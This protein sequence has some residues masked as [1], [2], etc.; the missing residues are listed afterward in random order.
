M[1]VALL[2]VLMI[3]TCVVQSFCEYNPFCFLGRK[4]V[5]EIRCRSPARRSAGARSAPKVR[6]YAARATPLL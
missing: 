4:G 5:R 2:F 3:A 1:L 6:E